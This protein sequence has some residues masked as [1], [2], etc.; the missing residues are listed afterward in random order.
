[1]ILLIKLK[2]QRGIS[3]NNEEYK[4]IE[5]RKKNGELI[6][7]DGWCV[8]AKC[9]V[10]GDERDHLYVLDKDI[11]NERDTGT[12]LLVA[13]ADFYEAKISLSAENGLQGSLYTEV[14]VKLENDEV[15][16]AGKAYT[17]YLTVNSLSDITPKVTMGMWEDGGSGTINPNDKFE[18]E[19]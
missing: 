3:F 16:S 12:S 8:V 14:D 11:D 9:P 6:G 1:M 7:S 19:M 5:L 4:Y 2:P 10:Y 17:I 18:D 15:F 13:P